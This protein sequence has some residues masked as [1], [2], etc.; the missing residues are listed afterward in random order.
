[1]TEQAPLLILAVAAVG[2]LHTMVPDHWAP[3]AILARQQGWSRVQVAR[4]AALAGFGHT[5]STLVIGAIVWLAGTVLAARFGHA[6]SVLSS[7][8][9]IVFG[10]WIALGSWLELRE[11]HHDHGHSHF[12]HSHIHRHGGGP[13]HRHWHEHH[14]HDWHGADG[15]L[16]LAPEHEHVHATSSR[17]AL[18][19]ILGSSPMVEGIPAFFAASRYG[20]G[21]LGIMAV[22]FAA[23]T[24]VTYVVLCV[25]SASGIERLNLGPFEQYGEILSGAIIAA[26]G[27]VFLAVPI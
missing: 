14:E 20:A 3:I 15:N 27:V 12:G 21:L 7:L 2:V 5:V 24:I 23:S 11:Q 1:M 18:L 22:V 4:A 8:A 10:G 26:L 17:T 9:L 6:M 19:L 25:A 16:A 13:E